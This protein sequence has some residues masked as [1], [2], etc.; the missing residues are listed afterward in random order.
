MTYLVFVGGVEWNF[1]DFLVLLS[2]HLDRATGQFDTLE[3]GGFGC[4]TRHVLLQ[5]RQSFLSSFKHCSVTERR[6]TGQR[7]PCNRALIK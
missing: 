2:H 4:I 6:H 7:H 1:S 5:D 3:Q